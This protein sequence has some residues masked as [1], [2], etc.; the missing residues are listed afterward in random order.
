MFDRKPLNARKIAAFVLLMAPLALVGCAA[1]KPKNENPT[2][3]FWPPAPADPKI[4]YLTSIS[5]MSDVTKKQ[6]R[7]EDFLYGA[8]TTTDLPF[9]RP[10]G[11]RMHD[12]KL[13]VCDASAS[14]V[15]ILDF[16]KK[17]VRILGATGQIRLAKPIDVT[18]ASDGVK[19]IADSS[20]GA[21]FAYDASD[22]YAGR[23]VVK[24][25]RPISLAV[26]GNEL[27]V[28]DIGLS[29]V[30]VFDRFN[31]KELRTIG[32]QG[33]EQGK[34]GGAMGIAMDGQG[35][36]FVNDVI[37]CRVQKFSPDSKLLWSIGGLGDRAGQFVRPKLMTVDSAGILYVVDNAFQNVQMFD[38]EGKLL[39]YFGGA[40]P[41]P[42]AMD[43]PAGVCVTDNDLD[44]FE[45]YVHPAFQAQRLVMVTNQTGDNKINIYALGGL[46]PGK[47]G[48]D[49]G[50]AR[51]QGIFGFATGPVQERALEFPPDGGP[52]TAPA[53]ATR[54]RGTE[55]PDA[56]N[57]TTQPQPGAGR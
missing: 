51:V 27:Y 46:K 23:I 16:R 7:M 29:R 13:Y 37:G 8:D 40:G 34:F 49:I 21:I 2:F 43:A 35:N 20:Y 54:P 56:P 10:Y 18:V 50:P 47:T 24:D 19:Y 53:T 14:S 12:G 30:R 33:I 11:I 32:E 41:H 45:R 52:T 28:S 15:S 26:H 57:V 9:Q 3:M 4:Q 38:A 42:G 17:E 48:A 5:A 31:G 44:L 25:M 22:Q 1:E 39:T 36:L 55:G 6:D